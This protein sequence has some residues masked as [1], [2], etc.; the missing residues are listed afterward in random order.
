[1]HLNGKL[2][3]KMLSVP[4][5]SWSHG[6]NALFFFFFLALS[7]G[8]LGTYLIHEMVS[9]CFMCFSVN[10]FHKPKKE[11]DFLRLPAAVPVHT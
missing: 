1:M 9:M 7:D 3:F 8:Y 5:E 11:E 4:P 6:N 10:I 2:C